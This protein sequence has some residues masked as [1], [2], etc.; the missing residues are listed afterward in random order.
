MEGYRQKFEAIQEYFKPRFPAATKLGN[1]MIDT[2]L[3]N[4]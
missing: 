4:S 2:I 1:E 3:K